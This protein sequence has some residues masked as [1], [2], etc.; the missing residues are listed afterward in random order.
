MALRSDYTPWL[1]KHPN[2]KQ[3]LMELPPCTWGQPLIDYL[4]R[5]D[6]RDALHIPSTVQAWDLCT[7]DITYHSD[8]FGSQ[9]VYQKY[10]EQYR[11]LVYSGDVDGVVPTDGTLAWIDQYVTKLRLQTVELWYPYYFVDDIAGPQVAGFFE[12]WEGH[13]AFATVHGSGH[14]V[15]TYKRA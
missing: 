10:H 1:W 12:E 7:N 15:P 2:T 6:V 5:T 11:I 9:W 4:G 13:F 3:R 8:G 14:M